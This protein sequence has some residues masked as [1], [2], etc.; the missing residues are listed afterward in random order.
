LKKVLQRVTSNEP[1][2]LIHFAFLSFVLCA[3]TAFCQ[4]SPPS[5]TFKSSTELVLVPTVV[6][7][8][9]GKHALNLKKEDFALKADGKARPIAVFEEITTD[10]ARFRRATGQQGEYSNFDPEGEHYHRLTIIALDLIN[11]HFTDLSNAHK[12]LFGFLSKAAESGE[13]MCLL[14]MDRGGV[15]VIHGFTEDPKILADALNTVRANPSPLQYKQD[16]SATAPP[17][18]GDPLQQTLREL[19]RSMIQNEKQVESMQ[20]KDTALLTLDELN[21]IAGAFGGL[22]GRKALVWA[23]SGFVY[24]LSSPTY[25]MCEPACPVDQRSAIQSQYDHLWQTMN[26]SQMAIYSVDLRSLASGNLQAASGNDQFTHPYDIGDPQFDK[27]AEAKWEAQD[28]TSSLRLF[29]ENTGGRAFTNTNDLSEAFR[30]AVEDD[31][32]YYMLGFYVDRTKDKP[33]WHKLSVAVERKGT[34]IRFRNGFTQTNQKD[35]AGDRQQ[36]NLAVAS[37]LDFT[38]IPMTVSWSGSSAAKQAGKIRVQF[39]LVMPMNFAQIDETD[40]NHLALEIAAVARDEK[41]A[42]S[43]EMSE[44]IDNHL[45][46]DA[47]TQ[48]QQHGM[49]YRSALQLS[50]GVYTVRFVVRDALSG[51]IGSLAAPLRVSP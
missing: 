20:R 42:V 5:A 13:P 24:S 4:D 43:G 31:S 23:S 2:G 15:R 39:D 19:I 33:G 47:L 21:Q 10:T 44:K 46:A 40:R 27:A 9:S 45:L 17:P 37:P 51:R 28:V 16:V 14:A 41:D 36:L 25:L 35:S 29:A 50:P 38:G 26:N 6:T 49:T 11:T 48:I 30:Q 3:L 22:P 8:N 7:D 34:H 12:A 18:K 1:P 32:Q